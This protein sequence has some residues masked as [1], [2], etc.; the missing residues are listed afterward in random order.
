MSV[1]F[2]GFYSK[3]PTYSLPSSP[4][5]CVVCFSSASSSSSSDDAGT[6]SSVSAAQE[7]RWRQ[8]L[9]WKDSGLGKLATSLKDF[10]AERLTSLKLE[11][12][13]NNGLKLSVAAG[14]TDTAEEQQ[15]NDDIFFRG[16]REDKETVEWKENECPRE[17]LKLL[18]QLSA[19]PSET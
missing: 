14:D 16:V 11:K 1:R 8:I 10:G 13:E 15:D 12:E 6:S 9:E 7:K 17:A 19:V 3:F 4:L 2:S 18:D 5:A